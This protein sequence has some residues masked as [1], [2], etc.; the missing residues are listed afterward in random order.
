MDLNN[1][2]KYSSDFMYFNCLSF[3]LKIKKNTHLQ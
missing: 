2:Q 3:I 1:I